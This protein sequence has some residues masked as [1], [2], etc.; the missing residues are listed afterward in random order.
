MSRSTVTLLGGA[1]FAWPLAAAPRPELFGA[2]MISRTY[3]FAPS[4]REILGD[5]GGSA[6]S[7]GITTW[8]L[9]P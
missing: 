4:A 8:T 1:A 6:N 3:E 2:T 5:C 9:V 7:A